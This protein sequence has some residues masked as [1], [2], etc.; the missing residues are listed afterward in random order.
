MSEFLAMGGNAIFVW[1]SYALLAGVV[2]WNV[3]VARM[4]RTAALEEIREIQEGADGEEAVR[5]D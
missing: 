5:W 1:P 4:A 2:V 3:A